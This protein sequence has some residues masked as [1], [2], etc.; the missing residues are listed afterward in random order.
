MGSLT[1]S[2]ARGSWGAGSQS[3][4][5]CGLNAA[6]RQDRHTVF[7]AV[8][9]SWTKVISGA[10]VQNS[11]ASSLFAL[12]SNFPP[13]SVYL[14]FPNSGRLP[15]RRSPQPDLHVVEWPAVPE[16]FKPPGASGQPHAAVRP[17][18]FFQPC[19]LSLHVG[20]DRHA[21]QRDV[22]WL[23]SAIQVNRHS[24]KSDIGPSPIFVSLI[25]VKKQI[26]NGFCHFFSGTCLTGEQ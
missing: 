10:R 24:F 13:P 25:V 1:C 6:T 18:L 14:E 19:K 11:K 22:L 26:F 9:S 7:T 20:C 3:V 4:S 23:L 2:K 8:A 17:N 15:P 12:P 5:V 16:S 21:A